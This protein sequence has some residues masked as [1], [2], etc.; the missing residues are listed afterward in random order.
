MNTWQQQKC[1]KKREQMLRENI[2]Y[3]QSL[4]EVCRNEKNLER[5]CEQYETQAIEAERAGHHA[6][7][8]RLAAEN[9]KL[10]KH[11][12]ISSGMR[13]SLEIAHAMR[14]SNQAMT[15]IMMGARDAVN[16]LLANAA[17][18]DMYTAQ[19]ELGTMQ[20]Y[21]QVFLDQSEILYEDFIADKNA[22]ISEEGERYLK[23]LLSSEHK[24]KQLKLLRDTNSQL[25]KLQHNRPIENEGG[26]K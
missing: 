19:V 26:K 13:G 3:Q 5:F 11:Q 15:E 17:I 8:V 25:A 24:E 9:A 21:V 22:P 14:S 1:S 18:P 16:S 23:A 6:L 4:R 2:R 7:A 10:K 20:E 12:L